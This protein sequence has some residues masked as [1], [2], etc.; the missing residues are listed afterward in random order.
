MIFEENE[1][2]NN[3]YEEVIPEVMTLPNQ[4]DWR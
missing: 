4:D 2:W 1:I 3:V